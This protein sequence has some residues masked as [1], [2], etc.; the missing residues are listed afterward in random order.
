MDIEVLGYG[1]S[2]VS[3]LIKPNGEQ[4]L[5]TGK[6]PQA[7]MLKNVTGIPKGIIKIKTLTVSNK[8][9]GVKISKTIG[10]G[11]M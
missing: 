9:A 3:K 1:L 2:Y 4:V 7:L 10:R 6:L 8:P 5:T 11:G